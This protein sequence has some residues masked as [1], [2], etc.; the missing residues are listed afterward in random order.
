[1]TDV[2]KIFNCSVPFI[3]EKWEVVH[4]KVSDLVRKAKAAEEAAAKKA[5]EAAAAASGAANVAANV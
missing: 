2:S 1:M 4:G 5:L 3:N